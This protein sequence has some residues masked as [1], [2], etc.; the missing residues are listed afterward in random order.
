MSVNRDGD[1]ARNAPVRWGY[2]DRQQLYEYPGQWPTEGCV[3][4]SAGRL[5]DVHR[6]ESGAGPASASAEA[7]GSPPPAAFAFEHDPAQGV[8][9][10]TWPDGKVEVFR[11][12]PARQLRVEPDE[13]GA[14]KPV[15]R[16]G[17]PVYLYLAREEREVR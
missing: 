8:F 13:A 17:Q 7:P 16:L 6:K 10:L 4:D 2:D 11:D 14:M 5:V 15:V 12:R 9:R 1:P 3:Y